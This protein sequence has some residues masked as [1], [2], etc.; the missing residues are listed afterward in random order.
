IR[1]SNFNKLLI[2]KKRKRIILLKD[3]KDNFLTR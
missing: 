1:Y 3:D 2:L